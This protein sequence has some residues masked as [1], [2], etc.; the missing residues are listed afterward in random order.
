MI[1]KLEQLN[2]I[3]QRKLLKELQSR[4]IPVENITIHVDGAKI[5][6][7]VANSDEILSV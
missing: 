7:H 3:A 5:T 4:D 1:V 2:E 6:V